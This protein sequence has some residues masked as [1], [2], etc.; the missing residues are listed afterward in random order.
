MRYYI[1]D[2]HFFHANLNT[3]MDKR[4]FRDVDELNA[5][6]I[7]Q[8]NK[9]VHKNDEVVILG[10]LCWGKAERATWLVNQ[11]K[12]KL[13]MIRGNHDKFLSHKDFDTRRFQWVKDYAE[14]NDNG[15]K[16]ILSHYPMVCYN[17]QYNKDKSWNPKTYML[18]GHVHDTHDQRIVERCAELIRNTQHM[19]PDGKL[20]YQRA[21]LINC[22]CMYSDYVPWT[23]DEWIAY[24]KKHG[25]L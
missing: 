12:G 2:C 10:D 18:Y 11:L 13:F 14:L 6:M 17:G 4:G 7:A 1:A 21:D 8:W 25:R 20:E 9:R 22:F 16:V 24:H 19:D 15:R 23:L 5:Y 3:K